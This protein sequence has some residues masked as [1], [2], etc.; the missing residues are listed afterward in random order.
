[1]AAVELRPMT[2]GE[3]LDRTFSVY[4]SRFGL[5]VGIM[6]VPQ[7]FI[8]ALSVWSSSLGPMGLGTHSVGASILFAAVT[9]LLGVATLVTYVLTYA[10][11]VFGLSEVYLD[12]PTSVGQAYARVGRKFGRILLLLIMVGLAMMGGFL[13]LILPGLWVL[14]RT[15]VAVPAAV[16]EGLPARAALSRSVKLT[17]GHGGKILAAWLLF[18]VLSWVAALIFQYPFAIWQ[19]ASLKSGQLS[20]MATTLSHLSSFLVNVLIGP[21]AT[22]AFTLIYYD[23]RIRKE[24]FDLQWMMTNLD[25]SGSPSSPATA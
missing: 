15:A 24:A 25:Q 14:A 18:F 20:Y 9:L 5:F 11:T 21:I 13:L 8:L 10:A 22:I 12:R 4:K 17:Q 6:A 3:L 7:L 1:M 23:L 19:A 16:L 2:L